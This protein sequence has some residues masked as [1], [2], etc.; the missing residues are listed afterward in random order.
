MGYQWAL[1]RNQ[2]LPGNT[3]K[4]T[5][6]NPKSMGHSESSLERELL[7]LT[8]SETYFKVELSDFDSVLDIRYE[9]WCKVINQWWLFFTWRMVMP[10]R[11]KEATSSRNI[12]TAVSVK[13]VMPCNKS[14]SSWQ[15]FKI[16]Y[17]ARPHAGSFRFFSVEPIPHIPYEISWRVVFDGSLSSIYFIIFLILNWYI[18][19]NN[20]ASVSAHPMISCILSLSII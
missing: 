10:F 12:K 8:G 3:W 2:K 7:S 20:W 1:G 15:T 9:G 16:L 13:Q 14:N 19:C 18:F 6:D 4:W 17:K 11:D 5:H